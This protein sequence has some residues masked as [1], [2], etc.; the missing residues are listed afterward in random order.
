[1]HVWRQ[2]RCKMAEKISSPSHQGVNR[3]RQTVR[4]RPTVQGTQSRGGKKENS[5][6][7][8]GEGTNQQDGNDKAEYRNV[9]AMPNSCR[10]YRK[11]SVVH[12]DPRPDPKGRR[13]GREA[14]LDSTLLETTAHRLGQVSRL[15]LGNLPTE[16]L[17]NSD[18][19][20]VLHE[21][22]SDDHP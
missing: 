19:R 3:E 7:A 6:G 17:C 8:S 13:V 4:R 20:L 21:M 18:T 10:D 9:L 5:C 11:T 12:E 2:D 15:G 14:R 22:P 1:M 16:N